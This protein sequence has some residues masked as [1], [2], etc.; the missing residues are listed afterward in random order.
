VADRAYVL[1]L[2][3]VA[4]EGSAQEL[5]RRDSLRDSLLGG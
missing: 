4:D 2:G 1:D 5:R 3:R